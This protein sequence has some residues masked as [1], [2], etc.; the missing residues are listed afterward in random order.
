MQE[1]R[2]SFAVIV[3]YDFVIFDQLK[4]NLGSRVPVLDHLDQFTPAA[5]F[6]LEDMAPLFLHGV[7]YANARKA[8]LLTLHS[9]RNSL[10]WSVGSSQQSLQKVES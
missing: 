10:S 9:T 7:Q 5:Q 1:K 3:D 8:A 2:R 6:V 4:V